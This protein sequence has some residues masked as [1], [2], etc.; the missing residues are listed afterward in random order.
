MALAGGLA[1]IAVAVWLMGY[2][3]TLAL[4]LLLCLLA[5]AI[6]VYF[7]QTW[8]V[9]AVRASADIYG[10]IERRVEPWPRAMKV[11]LVV[12]ALVGIV[13]ATVVRAGR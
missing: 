9:R 13:V 8:A 12:A 6:A 2:L 5:F 11:G 10:R 3:D 1:V 7:E 4:V